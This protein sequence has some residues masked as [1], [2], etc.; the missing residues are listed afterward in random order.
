MIEIYSVTHDAQLCL[1]YIKKTVFKKGL[2]LN[3]FLKVYLPY[4]TKE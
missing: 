3:V 1:W 4:F 2:Y